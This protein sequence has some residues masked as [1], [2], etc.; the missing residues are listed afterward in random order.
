MK[1]GITRTRLELASAL[2]MVLGGGAVALAL[3]SRLVTALAPALD[4]PH[5]PTILE[6]AVLLSGAVALQFAGCLAGAVLCLL[7][8]APFSTRD[9]LERLMAPD[10]PMLS[11]ALRNVLRRVR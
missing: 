9:Q 8:W 5:Q 7:V 10:V 1:D 11:R 6:V 4:E 3:G 2:V